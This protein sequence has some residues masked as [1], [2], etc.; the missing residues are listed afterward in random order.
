MN[1]KVFDFSQDNE[2]NT[3]RAAAAPVLTYTTFYSEVSH[4]SPKDPI[5]VLSN[6]K[7]VFAHHISG[8]FLDPEKRT[9]FDSDTPQA[10]ADIK[11]IDCRFEEFIR[12]LGVNRIRVLLSGKPVRGGFAVSRSGN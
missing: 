11:K 2:E 6:P 1:R 7:G 12:W 4:P 5:L 3:G 10:M 9:A 8:S